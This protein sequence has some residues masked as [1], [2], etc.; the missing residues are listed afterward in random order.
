MRDHENNCAGQIPPRQTVLLYASE[1]AGRAL[2]AL[3]EE[4]LQTKAVGPPGAVP[5]GELCLRI[6]GQGV[7][8]VRDGW[9]LRGDFTKS[10]SRLT[11]NN[12]NH[13]LLVR[14]ARQKG[15][16][17][18]HSAVDA[19]AG[20][21]DDAF[22]LAAAGFHVQLYERNPVI[23][24]LLH[25]ALR[26]GAEHPELAPIVGRMELRM[27]DS[28]I[29]LPQ[30]TQPPDVVVLD[31]M[32]PDKQKTGLTKKK[33]QI[34]QQLEQPCLEEEALLNAALACLPRRIVVKRPL[35]GPFLAGRKPSYTLKG[36]T[37]RYDC[38]VPPGPIGEK[39]EK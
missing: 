36:K 11:P 20:L 7:S 35:K 24:L 21:G 6:D 10:L 27:G 29:L 13:E 1:D 38:I 15:S 18:P 23:A 16:Q 33:L 25:D 5:P 14:A 4:T 19:T 12:L 32:F 30:L 28:V 34:L 22:L 9:V 3:A 37:I 8:L 39:D 17:G 26:R 31:P 2:V